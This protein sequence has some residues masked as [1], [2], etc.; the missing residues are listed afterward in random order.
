MSLSNLLYALFAILT[1]GAI[2][3][4]LEALEIRS[5]PWRSSDKKKQISYYILDGLILFVGAVVFMPLGPVG[6]IIGAVLWLN[7]EK[8]LK[9]KKNIKWPRISRAS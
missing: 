6:P 9:R 1:F 8:L 7:H 3:W 4:G 2:S 5:C